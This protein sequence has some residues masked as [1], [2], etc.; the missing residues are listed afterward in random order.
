MAQFD[1]YRVAGQ[2][3]PF[4]IDIQSD[5]LEAADTR[6]VIPLVRLA[7]YKGK[8]FAP[9]N[10]ILD[11]DGTPVLLLTTQIATVPRRLLKDRVGT[12]ARDRDRIVRAIDT[13]LL[14]A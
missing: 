8:V 13:L 2:A 5:Y 3:I 4:V 11:V 6:V 10:P 12:F 1:A 7:A 14:G 9:L